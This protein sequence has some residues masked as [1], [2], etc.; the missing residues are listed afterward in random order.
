VGVADLL[1][2]HAGGGVAAADAL[3]SLAIERRVR[4]LPIYV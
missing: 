1:A 2:L 3:I 4:P